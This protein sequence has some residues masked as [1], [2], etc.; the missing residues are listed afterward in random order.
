MQALRDNDAAADSGV[1]HAEALL[2]WTDAAISR[3]EEATAKTRQRVVD[4]MGAEAAVDTAAIIGNFERMTRIADGTGIPLDA[5]VN[6][7]T[8]DLQ[9]D[10]R[11]R[12]FRTAQNTS[13]PGFLVATASKLLRPL[14][15]KLMPTIAKRLRAR[16]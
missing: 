11:L 15:F 8:A 4:E 10:L 1:A 3:D 2:T 9:E 14:V 7:L 12:E 5:P 16:A 6:A 13:R